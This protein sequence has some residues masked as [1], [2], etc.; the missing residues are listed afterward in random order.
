MTDDQPAPTWKP[1]SEYVEPPYAGY[2]NIVLL[3]WY[4]E[5]GGGYSS[6][7]A[8]FGVGWYCE[9]TKKWIDS[10][11]KKPWNN[12]PTH[13]ALECHAIPLNDKTFGPGKDEED[14]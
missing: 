4:V 2:T 9:Y 11:D 7:V 5:A 14:E 1:I 13:F 8:H 6:G 12:P 10:S 3:G